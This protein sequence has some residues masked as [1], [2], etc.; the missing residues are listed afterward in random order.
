MSVCTISIY[1]SGTFDYEMYHWHR[2]HLTLPALNHEAI[3]T[4]TDTIMRLS[5]MA[6]CDYHSPLLFLVP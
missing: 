6:S 1:L 5:A 2:R 3:Q 4:H